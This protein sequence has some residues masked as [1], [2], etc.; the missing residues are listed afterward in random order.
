MHRRR[1]WLFAAV[2]AIALARPASAQVSVALPH[3]GTPTPSPAAAPAAATP[4]QSGTTV[5][6]PGA[7]AKPP[8][9]VI[10]LNPEG[11]P[12]INPYDRDLEMTAPLTYRDRSLGEVPIVLTR[13]DRF[14]VS[15]APF[16]KLI[17]TLLSADARVRLAQALDGKETFSA[18]DLAPTGVTV[19]YDPGSLSVV[20][21]HIVAA[22]RAIEALFPTPSDDA[23]EPD[24]APANFSA[25]LN[26]NVIE[27]RLWDGPNAGFTTPALYFNGAA[28]LGGVVFEADGQVADENPFSPDGHTRFD[29]NY[30][31]FV[32]DQPKD[33]RRWYLGDLTPE[34][35]GLQNYVQMGGIGVSRQR[36]RFDQFRTAILQGNRQIVLQK[37]STVDVY[38]NG[39]LYKQFH[40]EAGSYDLSSLPLATGSNDIQIQVRDTSGMVQTLN[41]QSYFDPIDLAPGDYEY[42]A[43]FGKVSDT[44]R[45]SPTYD[46]DLAFSGYFRKAFLNRPAIGAGLQLSRSTQVVTG[47]TQFILPNGGRLQVEGGLSN[48]RHGGTGYS[49][50]LV[51]DQVISRLDYAD[52]ITFDLTYLSRRFGGLGYDR[53]NNS[54]ALDF[55]AQYTR[56]LN[57]KTEL[58]IGGSYVKTRGSI[59]DTYRFYADAQYR[60]NPKW[61][62]RGGVDYSRLGP[63][64]GHHGGLGFSI[65][66]I[67]QPNYRDRAEVSH[68]DSLDTDQASY[69]HAS[70]NQ[71]GSVGYGAIVS[72]T[73]NDSDAQAFAEYTGNRFD[74]SVSHSGYGPSL[75][76]VADTQITSVRVGTTLA[77]AGGAFGIGRRV[78]DS[79][80]ILYPHKTLKGHAVVAGQSLA[81]NDFMSK[82]GT[83]GGAVNGYLTSYVTQS[84]Q[85]DVENP[86]P[87][88]DIGPGVVRV[89]PPYHS[90]YAVRVGTDA[91]A[92]ATG[93]LEFA[94]GKPVPLVAGKVIA[95][96]GK[97]KAPMTF[98]TNSVGRFA[99]QNLRPGAAYRVELN[100]TGRHFEFTVPHDTSGLVDL[101]T[102]KLPPQ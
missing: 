67:F 37:D 41:Y 21:L 88:Y 78:N 80:A 38:R 7:P 86:P 60:I 4:P 11:R 31:R 32:Y 77:F 64:F 6:L 40:L 93:T 97:D 95:L 79:F 16:L 20:V 36:E 84:V 66:L 87:G 43:Y 2:S 14:L 48:A 3:P 57:L 55:T 18:D 71:I 65:S 46:G 39:T 44:F 56:A 100:E 96:D 50:G 58:L 28:R 53:P 15:T 70:S 54:S 24:I 22:D 19:D 92:S 5:P 68:D 12:D 26:L 76:H 102:V 1:A 34:I 69:V 45:Q 74:A 99:V 72:R 17:D 33:Y 27:S 62:V 90:G 29:R 89:R 91:F 30:A 61:S 8:E 63:A 73:G 42:A 13:D 85:Y 47:E 101:R 83:L 35:R 75:G 82:S 94:D 98:F 59:G 10:P 9:P 52:S 25:F 49:A 51:Y 23:G 81:Q